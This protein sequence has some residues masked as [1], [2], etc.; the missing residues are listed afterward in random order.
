MTQKTNHHNVYRKTHWFIIVETNEQEREGHTNLFT[1]RSFLSEGN[2][3]SK[4][5]IK[6]RIKRLERMYR[7]FFF[8]NETWSK[9]YET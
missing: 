4:R 2:Q 1:G 3:K 8:F 7:P 6:E 9:L 5:K